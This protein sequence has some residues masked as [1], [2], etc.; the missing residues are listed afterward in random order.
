MHTALRLGLDLVKQ[1]RAEYPAHQAKV[2]FYGLYAGLNRDHLLE[3]W[4]DYV[5]GGEFEEALLALAT[6][7]DSGVDATPAGVST[8]QHRTSSVVQRLEYQL[9]ARV[10]L[11]V[12]DLYAKLDDGSSLRPA[13]HVE[14]TRGCLHV[15]RHCPLT[16]VYNGRFFAV[17]LDLVME[18][19]RRQIAAGA[20]HIT[21]G[22]PDFFNGPTHAM[23]LV[24]RFHR[25]FPDVTFDCTIKVEHLL[26]HASHLP[27]LRAAGCVM[28]T[29]AFESVSDE[30]LGHLAKGHTRADAVTAIRLTRD[31]SIALRPTWIPFTPWTTPADLVELLE[32]IGEHGLVDKVSAVQYTIKLLLPPGSP[33]LELDAM[34]PY[35]LHQDRESFTY[36][37]RYADPATE[38]LEHAVDRAVR[39]GIAAGESD[40]ETYLRLLDLVGGRRSLVAARPA[41]CCGTPAPRSPRLTEQWFCCAEPLTSFGKSDCCS[42]K[43]DDS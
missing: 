36:R 38:A 32:F 35:L 37:W 39:E 40:E 13:G 11:P 25:E 10:R 22:D 28:I 20:R 42:P 16:P 41:S 26:R 17:P 24:E 23:R 4:A 7:L 3:T 27:G 1:L 5:I 43:G 30:V 29:S 15:C 14:A 31:L 6:T 21:F 34:Q 2:C 12:L 19:I 33:L 18:D 8:E 9:P